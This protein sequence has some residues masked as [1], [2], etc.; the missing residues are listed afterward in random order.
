MATAMWEVIIVRL[1][2]P[3]S[4]C[5]AI[6]GCVVVEISLVYFSCA[7]ADSVSDILSRTLVKDERAP[8]ESF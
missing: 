6:V 1:S 4:I 3:L 7:K 2:F 8:E 5:R